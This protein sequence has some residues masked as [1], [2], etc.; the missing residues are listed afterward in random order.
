M[1][2]RKSEFSDDNM[3]SMLSK[4]I[5]SASRT[6]RKVLPIIATAVTGNPEIGSVISNLQAAYA[7]GRATDTAAAANQAL[8][9][10]LTVD[11][12]SKI[13]ADAAKSQVSTTASTAT[14]AIQPYIPWIIGGGLGLVALIMITKK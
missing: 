12:I 11:Q 4:F 14:T 2:L 8:A 9:A 7:S 1:Y 13:M 3:G 5:K 10:G 6:F